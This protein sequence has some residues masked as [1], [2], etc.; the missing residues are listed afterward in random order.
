MF[1]CAWFDYRST[2]R[3]PGYGTIIGRP[4][5]QSWWWR[6]LRLSRWC[7]TLC[8]PHRMETKCEFASSLFLPPFFSNLRISNRKKERRRRR[9]RV[10]WFCTHSIQQ[11]VKLVHNMSA[12]VIITNQSLVLQNVGRHMAGN[13]SCAASN[14]EGNAE[15]NQIPLNIKCKCTVTL[16]RW[17][18]WRHLTCFLLKFW[19]RQLSTLI[20][21]CHHHVLII[22]VFTFSTISCVYRSTRL[23]TGSHSILWCF[24]PREC[25]SRLSSGGQSS[26]WNELQMVPQQLGRD[27]RSTEASLQ[28]QPDDKFTQLQTGSFARLRNTPLLRH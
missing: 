20:Q 2:E 19:C 13:I 7:S 26:Q 28:Q 9:K 21:L 22:F 23:P 25:R 6:L 4:R 12:N 5:H 3:E 16:T 24:T 15:S 10:W 11:G 14:V 8:F 17:L 1:L 18:T 27:D